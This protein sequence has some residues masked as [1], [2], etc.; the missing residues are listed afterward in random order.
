MHSTRC[1]WSY[2][3]HVFICLFFCRTAWKLRGAVCNLWFACNN[4]ISPDHYSNNCNSEC[5]LFKKCCCFFFNLLFC[6]RFTGWAGSS[7]PAFFPPL[8]GSQGIWNS[9]KRGTGVGSRER[10]EAVRGFTAI[11]VHL[12]GVLDECVWSSPHECLIQIISNADGSET[13]DR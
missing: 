5:C 12:V 7:I 4:Y 10:G 9:K 1:T 3:G 6:L 11:H 2:R 13:L 8:K